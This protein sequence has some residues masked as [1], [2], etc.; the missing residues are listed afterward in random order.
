[1]CG[2]PFIYRD[3]LTFLDGFR[4]RTVFGNSVPTGFGTGPV[5][6]RFARK[7]RRYEQAWAEGRWS[8]LQLQQRM[9]ALVAFTLPARSRNWRMHEMESRLALKHT[10]IPQAQRN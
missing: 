1:M 9:E 2:S 10:L 7:F 4:R 8:E 3:L 5:Q 6:S